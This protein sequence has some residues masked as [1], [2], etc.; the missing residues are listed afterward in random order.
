MELRLS[1]CRILPH[2]AAGAYVPKKQRPVRKAKKRISGYCFLASAS[3]SP[4]TRFALFHEADLQVLVVGV[5]AAA[6]RA[7]AVER[8]H[9]ERGDGRFVACEQE[10][11]VHR[12]GSGQERD[13]GLFRAEQ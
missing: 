4:A 5:G 10:P 11:T 7:E 8:G 3:T 12:L 1:G 13:G 2:T 6:D 9:A